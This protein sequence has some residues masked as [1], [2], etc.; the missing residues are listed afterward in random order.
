M[1]QV[2]HSGHSDTGTCVEQAIPKEEIGSNGKSSIVSWFLKIASGTFASRILGMVRE[3]VCAIFLGAGSA[4]DCFL[5]AF[6]IP[7]LFRRV[8]GE[9]AMEGAFLPTF[10]TFLARGR[11]KDAWRLASTICNLTALALSALILLL[12]FLTPAIVAILAPGYDGQLVALTIKLTRLML[13][14]ALFI[15]LAGFLGSLLL[16]RKRPMAYSFAPILFNVGAIAGV[17]VFYESLG[18]YSLALGIMIGGFGQM[19]AQVHGLL[20]V[21]DPDAGYRPVIDLQHPGVRK[22]LSLTVPVFMTSVVDK[23]GEVAKRVIASFLVAGSLSTFSFAFRLAL[24]PYAVISLAVSRSV[25]PLLSD[26]HASNDM[27]SFRR[28]LLEGLNLCAFLMIPTAVGISVL[29]VPLVETVFAYGAWSTTNPQATIMTS[30]ALIFMAASLP[31]MSAVAILTRACHAMLETKPPLSAAV[32]GLIINLVF[33]FGLAATPL[34]HAGFAIA[35]ALDYLAQSAILFG[36]IKRRLSNDGVCFNYLL[37]TRSVVKIIIASAVMGLVVWLASEYFWQGT[38][39]VAYHRVA[40]LLCLVV[41][42]SVVFGIAALAL[43][44]DEMKNLSQFVR[45]HLPRPSTKEPK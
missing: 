15:G 26:V 16:A 35:I 24:L 44:I 7:N 37:F 42:G 41:S 27:D 14:F 10:N 25:L 22:V 29:A 32:R 20:F 36:V 6:T 19:V 13:P 43:G 38:A 11:K 21:G 12:Y 3:V 9:M 4:M 45:R 34:G 40:S 23:L 30:R 2:F 31:F 8:F 28:H 18:I 5:T 39:A 33:S 17:L 1:S